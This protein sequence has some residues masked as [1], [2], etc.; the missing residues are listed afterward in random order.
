[1]VIVSPSWMSY[2]SLVPIF[3]CINAAAIKETTSIHATVM[4][5]KCPILWSVMLPP[6][7]ARSGPNQGKYRSVGG[8]Q[9]AQTQP[10]VLAQSH[11]PS[12]KVTA[13]AS[14]LNLFSYLFSFI[15]V[16]V[17]LV[18][19]TLKKREQ[20]NAD[21]QTCT[22]CDLLF[23]KSGNYSFCRTVIWLLFFSSSAEERRWYSYSFRT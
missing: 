4:L 19:K 13:P 6:L 15:V 10:W 3:W 17:T 7:N 8:K 9:K 22:F 11:H 5:F 18:G 1:M 14:A 23:L 12:H 21:K 2:A 16:Y 20:S